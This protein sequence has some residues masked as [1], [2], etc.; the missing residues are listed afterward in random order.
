[1]VRRILTAALVA[2][3]LYAVVT[4]PAHAAEATN[5]G[6]TTTAHVLGQV[7]AFLDSMI[8]KG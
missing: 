5:A 1:M 4:A 7:G 3:A 6:V 8:G 2:F